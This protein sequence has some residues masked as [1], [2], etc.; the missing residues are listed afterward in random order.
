[1]HHT[2]YNAFSKYI[3]QKMTFFFFSCMLIFQ[4]FLGSGLDHC[5]Y[6]SS[7]TGCTWPRKIRL[8]R[9]SEVAPPV[10]MVFFPGNPLHVCITA[11]TGEAV[12]A[13]HE[14]RNIFFWM[15]FLSSYLPKAWRSLCEEECQVQ[16]KG[17]EKEAFISNSTGNTCKFVL[18]FSASCCAL[19]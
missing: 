8:K 5:W 13:A 3:Q 17:H 4:L 1:M 7:Q 11:Y 12:A 19:L 14:V 15:V 10:W 9:W 18:Y 2:F 6:A 16:W